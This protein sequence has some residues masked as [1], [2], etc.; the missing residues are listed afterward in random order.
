M[1]PISLL[2]RIF[3]DDEFSDND[4]LVM[5]EVIKKYGNLTAKDLV[6]L[7][8]K[9]VTLWYEAVSKQNLLIPFEMKMMNN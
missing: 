7:T 9:K 3:C 2:S 6:Q 8:H 5:Q 1:E 4:L